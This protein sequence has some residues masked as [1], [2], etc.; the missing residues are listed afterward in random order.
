[1]KCVDVLLCGFEPFG[2]RGVNNAWE[3]AKQFTRI[4]NIDVLKIPVSFKNAH[5]VIIGA[6]EKKHYDLVLILG[7][8]AA[9]IDYVRLERVAINFRDSERPDNDGIIGNDEYLIKG[10]PSAYLTSFP[11]K[12]MT[13]ALKEKGLRVKITNSAGTFVCNSV[14]YYILH[15]LDGKDLK[16]TALFIHLPVSTEIMSVNM[17]IEVVRDVIRGEGV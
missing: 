4:P 9:T 8:T 16:T 13:R 15:Y 11:I 3:V 17:M 1:M 2:Q 6:L 12:K 10:A 5:S 7:E 14:Y